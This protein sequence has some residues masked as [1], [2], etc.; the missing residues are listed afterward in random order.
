M[1]RQTSASASRETALN[2]LKHQ[3][4]EAAKESV[5]RRS[6]HRFAAENATNAKTLR[7]HSDST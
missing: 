4:D 7:A 3:Q 2:S 6:G 5:F 1:V